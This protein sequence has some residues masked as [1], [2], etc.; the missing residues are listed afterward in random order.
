MERF[1]G[2]ALACKNPSE[3]ALDEAL[4]LWPTVNSFHVTSIGAGKPGP[5]RLI[6]DESFALT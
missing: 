5:V 4:A 6:D 3:V 2:G 1:V